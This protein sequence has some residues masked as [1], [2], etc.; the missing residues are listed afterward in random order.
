MIN[1]SSANTN[2]GSFAA[3][4]MKRA[5]GSPALALALAAARPAT[6]DGALGAESADGL[7]VDVWWAKF[8]AGAEVRARARM[9][10]PGRFPAHTCVC[11]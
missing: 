8:L 1:D 5:H 9:R 3:Q 2:N 10:T 4:A 11:R 7:R 6:A